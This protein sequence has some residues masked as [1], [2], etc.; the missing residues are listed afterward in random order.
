MSPFYIST[1][2]FDKKNLPV[3]D[4]SNLDM[5]QIKFVASVVTLAFKEQRK[6]TPKNEL[7]NLASIYWLN[8]DDFAGSMMQVKGDVDAADLQLR[9]IVKKAIA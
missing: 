9:S 4:T 8:E 5:D 3:F 6:N 7:Y 2:K 1:Q